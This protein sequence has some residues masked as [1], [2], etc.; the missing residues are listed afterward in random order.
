MPGSVLFLLDCTAVSCN[1]E[2]L[3]EFC[4][5]AWPEAP[6]VFLALE[7]QTT[8]DVHSL[9]RRTGILLVVLLSVVAFLLQLK[10]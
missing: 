4:A 6:A 5:A 8:V 1:D 3:A 9:D 7:P 10:P 2:F